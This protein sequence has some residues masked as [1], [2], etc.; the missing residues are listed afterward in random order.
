VSLNFPLVRSSNLRPYFNDLPLVRLLQL[1]TSAL[2]FGSC[3]T[4]VSF[5]KVSK[6]P[7]ETTATRLP[8]ILAAVKQ[9][10]AKLRQ[11]QRLETQIRVRGE[12]T[13]QVEH[14]TTEQQPTENSHSTTI[15]TTRWSLD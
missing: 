6:W 12:I 14:P 10:T 5:N 4:P 11:L 8:T 7:Q 15:S 13:T 1:E 9:T 2:T 3:S